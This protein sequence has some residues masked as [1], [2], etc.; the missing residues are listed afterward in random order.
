MNSRCNF[1]ILESVVDISVGTETETYTAA[2]FKCKMQRGE[3]QKIGKQHLHNIQ[4]NMVHN[5]EYNEALA[6]TSLDTTKPSIYI[7][8]TAHSWGT[9]TD[10]KPSNKFLQRPD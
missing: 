8:V 1:E 9:V 6:A 7:S 5:H 4:I 10:P 3:N 2:F